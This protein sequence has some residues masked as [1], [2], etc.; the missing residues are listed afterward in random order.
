SAVLERM[1]Y[2]KLYAAYSRMGRIERSPKRLFKILVYG[3]MNGLYS[4]RKLERACGRDINFMYLLGREQ[5]PDHATIARFR[6]ERLTEVIDDLFGQLIGQLTD[7]GELSLVSAFIDGT[8]LEANANRYSFVWKK[9]TQTNE[10][11]CRRK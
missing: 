6:G 9:S 2:S 1:D 3:C 4:S 7:A 8:K 10:Q 5:A 11:S